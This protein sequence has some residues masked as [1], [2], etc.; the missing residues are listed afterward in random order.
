MTP[1]HLHNARQF[2]KAEQRQKACLPT[3]R[4]AT[5]GALAH[6]VRAEQ[7]Q[8]STSKWTGTIGAD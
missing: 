2:N 6:S 3:N 8:W 7:L 4:L 1:L 5:A